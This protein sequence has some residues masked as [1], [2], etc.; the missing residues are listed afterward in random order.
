M[1]RNEMYGALIGLIIA[2][3]ITVYIVELF[4]LTQETK[5]IVGSVFCELSIIIGCLVGMSFNKNRDK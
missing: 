4:A 2:S 1:P 3:V 5:I